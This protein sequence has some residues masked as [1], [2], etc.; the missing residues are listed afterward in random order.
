MA[1]VSAFAAVTTLQRRS[2]R[3]FAPLDKKISGQAVLPE[4][5]TFSAT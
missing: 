3:L 1:G 5:T 4:N 2:N